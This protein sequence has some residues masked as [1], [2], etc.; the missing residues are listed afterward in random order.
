LALLIFKPEDCQLME[1]L[2]ALKLLGLLQLQRNR[3]VLS[4]RDSTVDMNQAILL[5]D[6]E[7]LIMHLVALL[8]VMNF[9]P[10]LQWLSTMSWHTFLSWRTPS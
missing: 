2:T 6:D 1:N 7:S 8:W 3:A 9:D 10:S 5:G 4:G